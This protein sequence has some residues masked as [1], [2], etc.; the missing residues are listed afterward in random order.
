MATKN[1]TLVFLA[2]AFI[3]CLS[4]VGSYIY[5]KADSTMKRDDFEQ[6]MTNLAEDVNSKNETTQAKSLLI[7]MYQSKLM[8]KNNIGDDTLKLGRDVWNIKDEDWES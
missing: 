7:L 2:I 6:F 3:L 4:S 5:Y 8:N 1:N